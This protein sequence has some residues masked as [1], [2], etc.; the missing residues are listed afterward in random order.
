MTFGGGNRLAWTDLPATVQ[1][2]VERQLGAPVTEAH[3]APG[4]FSPGLAARVVAANGATAFVKAISATQAVDGARFHRSEVGVA[5]RLPPQAPA[6]RFLWSHD[7]GEWVVLGFEHVDGRNPDLAVPHEREAVLDAMAR[8]AD[9]LTPSP[10]AA[11]RVVDRDRDMFGGWRRLAARET[12][13]GRGDGKGD[14]KDD[15]KVD[16][17]ATYGHDVVDA[18]PGL[19]ELEAGWEDVADGRTLL[20]GDVRSDNLILT[21]GGEVLFVDWPFAALGA[22][23]VDLVLALPSMVLHGVD[24][25]EVVASHPLTRQVD[26]HALDVFAVA[27]AGFFVASSLDP[28]PPGLP[29]LR[30][31]Q[32]DQ[33]RA[34]LGWLRQRGVL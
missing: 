12:G 30:S 16:G 7:D 34:A 32:R 9:A 11:P 8:L 3:S 13:D 6:P 33:G 4:G 2:F 28:A 20:H 27:V 29:T 23:W 10:V 26:P 22:P 5:S 18:V 24:P 1:G 21:A 25:Q 14:G 17:L 31:F 15:G 19:A